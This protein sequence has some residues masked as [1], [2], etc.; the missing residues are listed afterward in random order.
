MINNLNLKALCGSSAFRALAVAGALLTPGFAFADEV[1]LKSTDGT[2]NIEG[3]LIGFED[4]TY[5]VR[6]D[7]GDLRISA[8]RVRCE[9]DACPDF[10]VAEADIK[11][12]GADT[13]AQGM[14]PLLLEGYAGFLDAES[15]IT[16]TNQKGEIIA[17]FIGEQG[18]GDPLGSYLVTS[19]ATDDAFSAL[20]NSESEIGLASRRI[21]PNEARA[22][23]KAGAGSMISPSQ[24]HIVA[25]D[26]LVMIVHP[27]NP[28]R[29]LS[30]QDVA[31]IYSGQIKN[32]SE[33]GGKDA[34][35]TL[36]DRAK[37]SGNR[38]VIDEAVFGSADIEIAPNTNVLEDDTAIA[39]AVNEDPN[40]IG[41]V[42]YAFQRGAK[43]LALENSCGITMVPDAFSAR[44]EEYALQRRLY[45][46]NRGDNLS[47]QS[48]EFLTFAKSPSADEVIAKAGF[49][50]LG[51]EK[52]P[53]PLDGSR[54]RMLLDPKADAY[55][56]GVMREMLGQMVDFDRLSTTFRFRTGSSKLDERARIDMERLASFL[57]TKPSGTTVMF[58]GFT[59]N[60]GAF[61]SN[62]ALSQ[63]RAQKVMDELQ[64]FA[65]DRL[66]GLEMATNGYGEIAPSACNV[67]EDG[68]S[69]NRRVEVWVSADGIAG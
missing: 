13:I 69:I 36:Y 25:I 20:L 55:E 45:L 27:D 11:I 40:A 8:S 50:G 9:G 7:L 48:Q 54:A 56:A 67:S 68:R 52:K 12:S 31:A 58:V 3:E 23:K 64:S 51:V 14:M 53:Q 10:E 22:L 1:A 28:L 44:T 61:D 24:E 59:D 39:A 62:R 30:M 34:P 16:A 21:K 32:W 15:T 41:Y 38:A 2:V 66:N 60:V 26:S 29:K 42:S 49:I 33:V 63:S 43:P 46:Y 5:I 47:D 4:N 6:T 17:E 65:G 37:G 57:E 35:I 18:F 19:S